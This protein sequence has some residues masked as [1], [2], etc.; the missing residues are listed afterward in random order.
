MKR[1]LT[2]NAKPGMIIAGD[3][4]TDA[5]LLVVPKGTVLDKGVIEGIKSYAVYDFFIE[6]EK[7]KP[8]SYE[9]D[10]LDRMILE[11]DGTSKGYYDKI[12]ETEEFHKFEAKFTESVK[13]LEDN[14]N[15]IVKLNNPVCVED[16]LSTVKKI[17]D[18]FKPDVTLFDMI[19][20]I[21]GYDDSTYIHS[22]NVALICRVTGEWLKMSPADLDVLTVAGLL[23]DIGKVMVPEDIIK[24][25]GKLTPTEYALVQSHTVHG[26]NILKNQ[27]ID[28]RIKRAALM[29]HE[30]CDGRGYPNHHKIDEI[31]LIARIVAIADVYDAMTSNRVY[32][33]GICPFNVISTFEESV[34]MFDPKCLFV[35]LE[36]IAH[37]YVNNEVVL[38]DELE[39]TVVMINK[40]ALA[41]PGVLV[42][43]AYI[44]LSRQDKL[45]ITAIK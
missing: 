45:K 40:Y 1:I 43:G 4:Y 44:D 39:G 22:L 25:P 28:E 27:P 10:D 17:T 42:G 33:S 23:H 20:C 41:K 36:K 7:K 29:H 37:S 19:H 6:E 14:I 32:R 31:D 15:N 34:D 5:G 38:N 18:K 13:S 35:F 16:L 2:V 30:R 8:I 21:E 9:I 12:K 3:V 11:D 26:Y 24:K